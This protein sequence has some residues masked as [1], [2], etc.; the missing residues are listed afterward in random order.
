MDLRVR[1]ADIPPE[2]L[3]LNWEFPPEAV[4]P[5]LNE[6]GEDPLEAA[7]PV[8]AR[9]RLEKSGLRV[10]VQG[11]V[12]G[13]FRVACSRCLEAF[14]LSVCEEVFAVLAPRGDH[15][16][17]ERI[18]AADLD[19]EYYE[20]EEVDL[21]PLIREH[22]ILGLPARRICQESCQGLCPQCGVNR[23]LSPCDCRPEAG[24]PGLAVLEALKDRL[25]K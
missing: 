10:V 4:E 18:S 3:D 22:L 24:H 8:K 1:I 19:E 20:G 2:G 9:L 17:K 7:S 23:N 16:L 15:V 14:D 5:G 25:S 12:F 21:W 13:A 11:E 6:N